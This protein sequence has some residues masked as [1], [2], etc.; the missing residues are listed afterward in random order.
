MGIIV[1]VQFGFD[2]LGIRAR[3]L[4]SPEERLRSG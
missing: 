4:A 2:H 3:S 1:M